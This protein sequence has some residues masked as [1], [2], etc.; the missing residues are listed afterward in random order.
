MSLTNYYE[1][2]GCSKESS[3]EDI[4]RAYRALALKFHPDKS[5]PEQDGVKFQH[6]LEAWQVLSNP[7]LREEYDATQT[8]E[9]LD[10]ES[11]PIYARISCNDLETMDNDEN[12]LAYPC[13]CGGLYCVQKKYVE[14]KNQLIQVPCLECTFL[15]VIET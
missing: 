6:V 15:I 2:L 5:R 3:A 10:S 9:E 13:R 8:Q 14:A 1:I 12:V 4:K 7:K 11:A